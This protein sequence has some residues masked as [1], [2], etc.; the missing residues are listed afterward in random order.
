[1][2]TKY[3]GFVLVLMVVGTA[4]SPSRPKV[5]GSSERDA[6]T[7][8][9]APEVAD[10]AGSKVTLTTGGEE[11]G[12]PRGPV[13]TT[14]TNAAARAVRGGEAGSPDGANAGQPGSLPGSS[15]P[16]PAPAGGG[17]TT[18]G[19]GETTVATRVPVTTAAERQTSGRESGFADPLGDLTP[20]PLDPPPPYAD[21]A[22]GRLSRSGSTFELRVA[23]GGPVA[24]SAPDGRTMNVASFYDVNG[25][26]SVD[27]EVWANLADNG[28]AASWFDDTTGKASFGSRSGVTVEVAGQELVLRFPAGRLGDATSFRWSLASAW[29]RYEVISTTAA[30]QDDAPDND[31]FARFQS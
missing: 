11:G 24:S 21:L 28:W 8:R 17:D 1:M 5:G 20:S 2:Q 26:G 14:T 13:V 7:P 4:C 18:P 6:L 29:G 16:N 15:E 10:P 9:F 30:A 27:Y 3:A 23:T 25:D 12:A 22:G 31:G 19:T